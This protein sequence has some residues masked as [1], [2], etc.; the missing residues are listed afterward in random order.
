MS[1]AYNEMSYVEVAAIY[2][3]INN[4]PLDAAQTL[5]KS[6]SELVGEG[7]TMM[8]F[9][10]GAGRISVPIAAHTNM[11]AVDI[12][13]HM[14]K[15]SKKLA[16]DRHIVARQAVGTVLQTPFASNTFDAVITTNVLHQIEMWRDALNEAARVLKPEGLFLIGR[17]VLD[18][19]SCAGILRSMSRYFTVD[20]AP[21][22][23]PTDA[24]GPAL[25]QKIQ[26]MGGSM[27]RPVVASSWIEKVSANEILQRME[28]GVHNETWSLSRE[29]IDELMA[30][31][32]PWAQENI[33]DLDAVEDVKWEFHV[34][35]ISGIGQ[36]G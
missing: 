6:I 2:N 24:A 21:E 10:G 31:L 27:T 4:I 9:G 18:E 5:G 23:K 25:F 19:E 22:M 7:A 32:R 14:L 33:A 1:K 16:E 11:I 8:D 26:E 20:I 36:K 29:V 12:E 34:Y 30:K 13:H 35:P 15:A 3:D 28:D 17:D